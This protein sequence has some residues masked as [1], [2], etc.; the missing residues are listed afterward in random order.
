MNAIL[1]EAEEKSGQVNKHDGEYQR[2]SSNPGSLEINGKKL[3]FG[4]HRI[5]NKVREKVEIPESYKKSRKKL[6]ITKEMVRKILNGISQKRYKEVAT[7]L[8][9]GFG[10]SQ[11]R[12]SGLFHQE[13]EKALKELETT[14][15]SKYK[16]LAVIIDGKY[17]RKEQIVYARDITNT[18]FKKILGFIFTNNEQNTQLQQIEVIRICFDKLFKGKL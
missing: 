17:F 2:W 1:K 16:F 15:L 4:V 7:Q 10:L 9:D 14:D 3:R 12:V 6:K 8:T 13:A 11:S 5:R 18:G